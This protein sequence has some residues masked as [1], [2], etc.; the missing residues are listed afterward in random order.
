MK[1]QSELWKE[2]MVWPVFL[3]G[4][5]IFALIT[6]ISIIFQAKWISIIVDEAVFME[7]DVTG[8]LPAFKTL[9]IFI[10]LRG[11]IQFLFQWTA[12][13]AGSTVVHRMRG[14]T[15]EKILPLIARRSGDLSS[16]KISTLFTDKMD[17]IKQYYS[18]YIAQIMLSA[19]IPII[20]L[21]Y[22]FPLDWV[23]G[24]VFI[25]TAPL[26]P[27]FMSLIGGQSKKATEY[28]WGYLS[29]LADHFAD[30]IRG[31]EVLKQ[32]N[33]AKQ[34]LQDIERVSTQYAALTMDIL[35]VTFLS[36][37]ALEL[38][39]TL[40]TAVVAVE[41][42][43][44]LLGSGIDFQTAFFILLIAPEF[45]LPLRMLGL[46]FH[47]GM[48]GQ[49][50][51]IE[52]YELLGQMITDDASPDLPHQIHMKEISLS[53]DRINFQYDQEGV[54]ILQDISFVCQPGTIT[55]LIGRSGSG[56]STIAKLALRFIEP[57]QG[58]ILLNDS[59]AG[60]LPLEQWYRQI[61]WIGQKSFYAEGSV[62]ENIRFANPQADDTQ[63]ENALDRVGLLSKVQALPEGINTAVEEFGKN[64]SGGEVQRLQLA[65]AIVSNA[66][67]L[68]LDEPTSQLD[69]DLESL[70]INELQNLRKN[71]TIL[72]IA[73]RLQTIF[74]AD[75]ILFLENGQIIER[76]KHEALMLR[77]GRYQQMVST[78][79][80]L[81]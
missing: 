50:A 80:I 39:T 10:V 76:G 31:M 62:L 54:G 40:S 19:M 79:Q 52:Y 45:Y 33:Q 44:R 53:F 38:L 42:G 63:I 7:S 74:H 49:T 55:A 14:Y 65:R 27:F 71:R 6:A 41:I 37:L 5:L 69:P 57:D 21:I 32:F 30:H 3:I 18:Q 28:R 46:K 9:I 12:N 20:L 1:P 22:V 81:G 56:K 48:T 78:Y 61:A 58:R 17:A 2:L 4:M 68:I 24:L 26:I 51:A 13:R 67:L 29:R 43:L 23:S 34:R 66:P 11:V 73:H 59:P 35:K 64:F 8:L 16:G 15:L 72:L 25:L 47:S 75:Q 36:A 77:K 60:D 70:F